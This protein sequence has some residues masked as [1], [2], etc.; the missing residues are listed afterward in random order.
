MKTVAYLRV[1]TGSQDRASQKLAILDRARPKKVWPR[2]A[3]RADCA[4]APKRGLG[5]SR[6]DG[7]EEEIRI[8][9]QKQV[10]KA[11]IA[12]I[13]GVSRTA[14][15][16]FINSRK[17]DSKASQPQSPTHRPYKD[18]FAAIWAVPLKRWL[19]RHK[20][21]HIHFTPTS[22]S[23]LNMVERLFR[24]LTDKRIRRGVFRSVGELNAAIDDYLA[25]HNQAPKPF[26]WTAKASDILE[27]VKRSRAALHKLQSA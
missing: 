12:K 2:Q 1:W 22:A 18:I 5:K 7:K 26:I 14:M 25:V 11:S 3:P 6:L 8:L 15:R 17:L 16:H 19:Q 24:D 21:V 4:A 9:L 13:V 10:S 20:R 27:K 23:W